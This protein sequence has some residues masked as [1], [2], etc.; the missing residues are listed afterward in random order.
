MPEGLLNP[1]T[2]Q[3]KKDLFTFLLTERQEQKK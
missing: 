3:Q 1:L 2:E